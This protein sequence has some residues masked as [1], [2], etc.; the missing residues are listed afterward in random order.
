MKRSKCKPYF[1]PAKRYCSNERCGK[2]FQPK[3]ARQKYHTPKCRFDQRNIERAR[4][5]QRLAEL[6]SIVAG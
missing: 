2:L 4:K 5:M 3:I 6:E 1:K